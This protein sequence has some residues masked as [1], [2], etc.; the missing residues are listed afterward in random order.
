M[1]LISSIAWVKRGIPEQHPTKYELDDKEM[2]RIS[3][4]AKV[5]LEDAQTE[6]AR[7][8][9]EAKEMDDRRA[10]DEGMDVEN[11]ND[12][13]VYTINH[14]SKSDYQLKREGRRRRRRR[15]EYE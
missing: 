10:K 7:A 2:E 5:E 9:K 14:S 15:R 6:L 11:D 12:E 13:L 8:E 1:S 3:A 4:L